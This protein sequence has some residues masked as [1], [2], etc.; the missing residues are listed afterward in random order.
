[1][2]TRLSS[3]PAQTPRA[4]SLHHPLTSRSPSCAPVL[5]ERI[6]SHKSLRSPRSHGSPLCLRQHTLAPESLSRCRS[7]RR[8]RVDGR[9]SNP[10]VSSSATRPRAFWFTTAS[11]LSRKVRSSAGWRGRGPRGGRGGARRGGGGEGGCAGGQVIHAPC[12]AAPAGDLQVLASTLTKLGTDFHILA[13]PLSRNY[14]KLAIQP[15]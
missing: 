15:F 3:A 5:R 10:S 7:L 14:L 1:M 2:R 13:S 11:W 4:V 12:L 9:T 6:R 8:G